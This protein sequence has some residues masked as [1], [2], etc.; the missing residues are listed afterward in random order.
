MLLVV[1][2]GENS[3]EE[4][5]WAM[6]GGVC[7]IMENSLLSGWKGEQGWH[8]HDIHGNGCGGGGD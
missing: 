1:T 2:S 6:V 5:L 4:P 8:W 3:A 7:V